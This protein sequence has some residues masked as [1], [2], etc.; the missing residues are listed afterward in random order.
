MSQEY[1][2]ALIVVIQAL[3]SAFGYSIGNNV[4]SA[5]ITLSLGVWIMYR[6]YHKGDIHITGARN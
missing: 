5:I 3:F 1:S 2:A 4:V 6:R